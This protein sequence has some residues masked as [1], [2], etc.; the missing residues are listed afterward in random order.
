MLKPPTKGYAAVIEEAESQGLVTPPSKGTLHCIDLFAG[1]GGLSLGLE[2][3]GFKP[4]LF[5]ELNHSAAETYI[6]NRVGQGIIPYGDIYQLT[7][8]NLE[9]LQVNWKYLGIN[10]IDLVCGG[11]PCQGYSG[12]GHRRT[13]KLDKKDIPSNHLYQ[14]MARVIRCVRPRAFLFENVRGLLT[15]KWSA[16]GK[17]GEVFKAVLEEFKS[18]PD[19]CIRWQLVHAK[20]YGVPQNRPRVLMVGIRRDLVEPRFQT[21]LFDEPVTID[22]PTA[23]KDGFLPAPSGTAPTLVELLSDLEDP[24]YLSKRATEFYVNNPKN[25]LQRSLRT[26]PDG[27]LLAKGDELTEQEYSEHAD[28]IRE[29]FAYMIANN[30][31]IPEKY[32]TKKFAQRVFPREW[33]VSGPNITATSL[34]ED[35][36]HYSQPRGPTV[37][38][39]ARIQTFPDWYIFRGPRTTGGRRR[40]GD[41]DAG[42]WDR[43]VPR[44]TQI[45]NAVPV[46]LAQK[47]GAHLAGILRGSIKVTP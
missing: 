45:G 46:Q 5:S 44:Y 38:E 11:P 8:E 24:G 7:D 25:A 20:D 34:P 12:I 23:V 31:E 28:Y 42:I 30:G 35:Y 37:R 9:M 43:D 40:A 10:E 19:Y 41:P 6:A 39:W 14:E 22:R 3:S 33:T 36:V 21:R 15:S 1:C 16:S 18:I 29:K 27:T 17:N 4:L 32:K 13:F 47:V 2:E 26:K